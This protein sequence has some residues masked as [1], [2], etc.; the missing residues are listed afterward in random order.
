MATATATRGRFV[1]HELLTSD[2]AGAQ[3]FYENVVGWKGQKMEGGPP[4]MPPY[5]FWMAGEAMSGGFMQ[6][7][8]EA[9]NMGAPPNWMTYIGTDD[10]DGTA[11]K[12]EQLGGRVIRQPEDIPGIGR[13]A[14]LQDPQG[15]VFAIYSSA[16]DTP[17]E[18][19]PKQLEFSW[20]E[21]A[22]T[23]PKGAW[24]FY[25]NLFDWKETSTMDMGPDAG[26]YQ[27]F[28]RD[29]FT[30]GGIYK[31]PADMPAPS[32][33]LP[34]A[35]VDSADAAAERATKAGGTVI[36][37]PMEVPGGDRIAVI[38]DPQGA[39]FAVHSKAAA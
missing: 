28:G 22:T 30:Y 36:V 14:I 19:D 7:P 24:D 25:S 6:L 29:R 18:Q 33:W 12:A 5:H 10:V 11:Q 35:M 27:M 32:N 38:R 8:D 15:A 13:F 37:G 3:R 16:N 17:E 9:K 2:V 39:H 21:L 1:W 26:P 31:K 4:D 34:Y 23:D 20:H